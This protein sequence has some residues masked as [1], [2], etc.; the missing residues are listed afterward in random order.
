[1]RL[2]FGASIVMVENTNE[3]R[4]NKATEIVNESGGG[5]SSGETPKYACIRAA[6]SHRPWFEYQQFSFIP[7]KTLVL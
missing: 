7:V 1:M 3:A 2:V 6:M 4:E 5:E